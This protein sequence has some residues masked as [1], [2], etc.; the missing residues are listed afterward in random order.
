MT[1][2]AIRP[3]NLTPSPIAGDRFHPPQQGYGVIAALRWS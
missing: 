2:A 1:F 3:S